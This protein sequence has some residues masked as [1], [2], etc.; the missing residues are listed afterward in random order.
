MVFQR[1]PSIFIKRTL[2]LATEYSVDIHEF[3]WYIQ[4]GNLLHGYWTWHSWFVDLPIYERCWFS[5]SLF[6]P[7][8]SPDSCCFLLF[9]FHSYNVGIWESSLQKYRYIMRDSPDPHFEMVFLLYLPSGNQTW[10]WKIPMNGGFNRKITDQW[11]VFHYNVWLPDCDPH[12]NLSSIAI[13]W[14]SFTKR[15][16]EVLIIHWPYFLRVPGPFSIAM[17]V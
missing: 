16:P 1:G 12:E 5:S 8:I 11:S 9:S 15:F 6:F 10:Q 17:F 4:S 14:W 13:S 7:S 2:V 3:E